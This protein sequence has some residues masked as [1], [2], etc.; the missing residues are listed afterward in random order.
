[1]TDD[2]SMKALAGTMEER[3]REAAAAGCDIMLHCNG[4][5]A[6][7]QAVAQAAGELK[8]RAASRARAAL[9][10]LRKACEIRSAHGDER[11]SSNCCSSKHETSS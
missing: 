11:S 7:M 3:V 9:K 6:E 10:R 2:L 1:M 5:F 8:G 4:D